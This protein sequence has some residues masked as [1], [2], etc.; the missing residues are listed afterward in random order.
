MPRLLVLTDRRRAAAA[1]RTLPQAVAAALAGGARAIVLREKDLP[2]NRR[3][4]LAVAVA[5][6]VRTHA[7]TLIVASDV[8]LASRCGAGGVHLAAA[9][10]LPSRRQRGVMWYGRSC[11]S[12]AELRRAAGE[13]VDFAMLSPVFATDSKPG[14]GPALGTAGLSA[15]L[16]AVRTAPPVYALGGITPHR[17]RACRSAGAFGVAVMGTVMGAQR[18]A[19]V[20]ECLLRELGG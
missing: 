10:P 12:V 13:R 18:P 14:Y 16:A 17:V 15:A 8:A 20:I 19:K 3:A 7:G 5:E 6:V 2:A 9:D 4:D 11:H 1:G